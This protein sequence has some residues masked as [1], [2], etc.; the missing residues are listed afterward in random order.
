MHFAQNNG[1]ETTRRNQ[2]RQ[3]NGGDDDSAASHDDDDTYEGFPPCDAAR[4]RYTCSMPSPADQVPLLNRFATLTDMAR[5]RILR[6]LDKEELSVG[7]LARAVQ[8]PQSTVSRHLKLLHE[9]GWTVKRSEGTA[10]LYRV[11]EQSLSP[12]A[13]DLWA[14]TRSQLAAPSGSTPAFDHDDARLAEVLAERR[15]DSKSFFGRVGGEWDALRRDLFGES[16]TAEALLGM[17]AHDWVIAD[18][19]CGTGNATELLAPLVRKVIAVD[20]EPAMLDAAKKRLSAASI[21][22]VDFRLGELT[23]LPIDDAGLDAAMVLLVLHHVSQPE[24]AAVEIARTLKPGGVLLAVD[25]VTH[26]RRSYL[27]TMGHQHL[28]FDE[29]QVKGWAKAAGLKEVRYR[30]LRPSTASK[31]PGLFAATMRRG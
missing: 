9:S 25:M 28:G 2:H 29:K 23:D 10:S 26:D 24:A 13:R 30:R 3:Q 11:A 19:G 20:R 14:L 27:H 1:D 8:L 15:T 4:A 6:L 16:F 22:N 17:V 18:L 5:L 7:E 21:H 12:E 31:G